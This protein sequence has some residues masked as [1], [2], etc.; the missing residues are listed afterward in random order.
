MLDEDIPTAEGAVLR[1]FRFIRGVSETVFARMAGVSV[2]TLYRWETGA[3]LTRDFLVELLETH[4]RVPPEAVD[5]ALDAYRLATSPEEPEGPF[6]LSE[7][8]RRLIGRVAGTGARSGAETA[9]RELILERLRQRAARHTAW[10]AA[11]WTRL[12]TLPPSLQDKAVQ[13]H[14]GSER[15]WIPSVRALPPWGR[16][17]SRSRSAWRPFG[18]CGPAWSG[19]SRATT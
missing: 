12:K 9:R 7:T 13:G 18:C 5:G 6:A 4:L 17:H 3:F 1:Y 11:E 8:E 10:A 14:Q 15:S 2:S 16:R 19:A